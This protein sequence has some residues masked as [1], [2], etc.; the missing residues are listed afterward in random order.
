M[1]NKDDLEKLIQLCLDKL[2][3]TKTVTKMRLMVDQLEF[4]SEVRERASKLRE[5]A[6]ALME[7]K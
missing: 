3:M 7:Q 5:R 6:N 2:E 1:L 4:D